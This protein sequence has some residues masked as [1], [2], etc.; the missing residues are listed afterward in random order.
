MYIQIVWFQWCKA[1]K[2]NLDFRKYFDIIFFLQILPL[3]QI[4]KLII[5][6]MVS[7]CIMWWRTQQILAA[8]EELCG[9]V[10]WAFRPVT[11]ADEAYSSAW[12]IPVTCSSATHISLYWTSLSSI[13]Y[14]CPF[15]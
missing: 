6:E 9:S 3:L 4:E 8:Q 7:N 11:S 2:K 14:Y 15:H 5:W 10:L 13:G 12:F 1:C